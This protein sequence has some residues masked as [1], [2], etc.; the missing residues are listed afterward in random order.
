M[1][2]RIREEWLKAVA[3]LLTSPWFQRLQ[4]G[5]FRIEHY[6]G[7]LLETYH[8]A[9]MNPQIQAYTTMFLKDNPR[10][11]IT[12]FYKHA[13][14]EIGHDLMALNDLAVLGEDKEWITK[15]QPLA[16]TVAYNAYPLFMVQFRNPLA[17]LG[18]LFHLE[19]LPTNSGPEYM[20]NLAKIG[21]PDDA[22]TFVKE[23]SEIDIGHNRMMETYVRE[24]VKTEE[25]FEV[26]CQAVRDSCSL[27]SRMLFDAF[28]NGEVVF[29]EPTWRKSV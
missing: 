4:K 1:F 2:E 12:L 6:K 19:F 5:D 10:N 23:H 28:E 13:I 14:S 20:N 22:M 3:G 9:G 29:A 27:H 11:I 8:H 18:Y 26:V 16:S 17:Y 21:V 25:D 7:F 24:L 15:T